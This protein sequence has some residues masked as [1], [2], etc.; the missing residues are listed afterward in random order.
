MVLV[1]LIRERHWRDG[2]EYRTGTSA[3]SYEPSDRIDGAGSSTCVVPDGV[4]G[5]ADH[6]AFPLLAPARSRGRSGGK[7][8]LLTAQARF[9][10]WHAVGAAEG[11]PEPVLVIWRPLVLAEKTGDAGSRWLL[12]WGRGRSSSNRPLRL[13]W[14][15]TL[16]AVTIRPVSPAQDEA[17]RADVIMKLTENVDT[18]E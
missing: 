18:V 14:H 16:T 8:Q 12:L 11:L 17:A 4:G 15:G 13:V 9:R 5:D 2:C 1:R 10:T 7:G 3:A 6:D